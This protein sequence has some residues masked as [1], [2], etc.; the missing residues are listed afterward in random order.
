MTQ[1]RFDSNE[2]SQRPSFLE[3][4]ASALATACAVA[5]AVL[6]APSLAQNSNPS[7]DDVAGLKLSD[8]AYGKIKIGALFYGDYAYYTD[9]GFGPQFLTQMNQD[10]PGNG[11]FN[12]FDITRTYINLFY[13]PTDAVTLRITPNIYRQVDVSNATGNGKN[14]AIA[15]SSNGN[16]GFR[17]KYGYI[18]FNSLFKGSS[19]FGKDYVRFGQT[20][21]PL[22]DWEE[23][24][25]G[26]RYVALTPWNYLSLSSTYTGVIAGGPI[27]V[28]G[29]E[30]FD[31]QAG[32][33]NTASFHSI[34]TND[35]KQWMVRGTWY[36]FGT[37]KDRTGLGITGFY[38]HGYNT[39]T[40][41]SAS[42]KVQRLAAIVHWQSADG[43]YLIAGEYDWGRNAF[44]VGNLFSGAG[45]ADAFGLAATPTQYA[46]F[47][48]MTTAILGGTDTHQD[49]YDFFG[50]ARVLGP[51][52]VF[53]MYERFNPNS[54]ISGTNP[55]DFQ[56]VVLGLSYEYNGHLSFALDDQNL[57]FR[58]GQFAMSAAQIETFSKSLAAANPQGIPN[59]VPTD[60][61]VIMFNVQFSY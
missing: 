48:T 22:V 2:P 15:S 20:M 13:L 51:L 21:N 37:Q 7:G 32:A 19:V 40:P 58:H 54:A 4:P 57:N 55:L 10:G 41:D 39:K 26:Y 60:T 25:W 29:R 33:F 45:P 52:S 27:K 6:S 14:S 12:S 49:G 11:G 34:E 50:H 18:Q 38:D 46:T 3:S 35:K 17:L 47:S 42:T 24:L 56:R 53:G 59:A 61:N 16:L 31:Y 44:S 5:L 8:L 28:N 36:P 1:T 43:A 23:G 9:T 30:Y